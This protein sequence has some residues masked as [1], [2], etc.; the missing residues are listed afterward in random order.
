M[1]AEGVGQSCNERLRDCRRQ[2]VRCPSPESFVRSPAQR[3][4]ND[5]VIL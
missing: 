5:L 2:E 3:V 1:E 4:S